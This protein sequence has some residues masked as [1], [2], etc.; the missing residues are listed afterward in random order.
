MFKQTTNYNGE[1]NQKPFRQIQAHSHM[2]R[3]I[4]T[5]SEIVQAYSGI[6]RTLCNPRI[7][8]NLG[9]FKIGNRDIQ[10]PVKHLRW[11][12]LRKLL[13][14]VVLFGNY[15]RNVSFSHYL[16]ILTKFYFLLQKYLFYIK[17]YSGPG[18]G[19]R[20]RGWGVVIFF[21]YQLHKV[22]L[23]KIRKKQDASKNMPRSP[24]FS[25]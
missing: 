22:Y 20:G 17:K 4:Q 2:F 14:V 3:N 10:N 24:F 21:L 12:V 13:T 6:F 25:Q 7:I 23:K 15:F 18:M 19:G 1:V 8:Q 9:I 11:S 5:C 16:L